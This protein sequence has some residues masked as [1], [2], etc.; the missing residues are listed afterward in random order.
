[1]D[2]YPISLTLLDSDGGSSQQVALATVHNVTP[3]VDIGANVA[4]AWGEIITFS[5]TITD[6]GLPDTFAWLWDLGDGTVIS[7]TLMPSHIYSQSG[8]YTVTLVVTDDDTYT[9]QDGLMVTVREPKSDLAISKAVFPE[10][11]LPGDPLTYILA[12][13]NEGPDAADDVI[14]TDT[15]PISLTNL[16]YSSSGVN[17]IEIGS[18]PYSWLID[19][20]A[21]GQ[22]GFITITGQ[23]TTSI[24]SESTLWNSAVITSTSL[25]ITPTNNSAAVST[26]INLAPTIQVDSLDALLEGESFDLTG[27][28]ADPVDGM[29]LGIEWGDGLTATAVYPAGSQPFSL[30]HVYPDDNP[31]GT[32]SDTYTIRLHLSDSDGAVTSETASVTVHNVAPGVTASAAQTTSQSG[33]P[34]DFSGLITDPGLED[35]FTILWDFGD[36]VTVT[37]SLTPTHVY[38]SPGIYTVSLTV[39]DDDGGMGQDSLV[40]QV[41]ARSLFLPF[42]ANNSCHSTFAPVDVVLAIDAS[43]SMLLPTEPG[44]PTK[45]VVAKSAAIAFLELLPFPGSQAA[46][47]GFNVEAILAHPLATNLASLTTAVQGL[48]L[49]SATRMDL[50]LVVSREELVGPRHI[51]GYE[52]VVI[53]LTDGI[54]A[55]TTE[56]EVL[57]EAAAT[58]A[59]GITIYTIGLGGDVNGGLLEAMASSPD[60]YYPA[61]STTDLDDIYSQIANAIQCQE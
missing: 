13:T 14:I 43:D 45:F 61:P 58:K 2:D 1:V 27:S 49:D 53:F 33:A 24:G 42:I 52:Q 15:L 56:T 34:L 3:T 36:G 20:L 23:L 31:S 37:G 59:A 5:A 4:V 41:T 28:L 51:T 60:L 11:V 38:T 12:F 18:T 26:E 40:V 9:G 16:S 10:Q 25:D 8:N 19:E 17:L 22:S 44:G 6:P 21:V 55:G 54:P 7:N 30:T 48:T 35:T 29:E 50:A 32:V 47:V 39:S 57:A 46:I